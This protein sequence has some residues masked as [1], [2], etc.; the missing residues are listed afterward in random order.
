MT[1]GSDRHHKLN[2]EFFVKL[3]VDDGLILKANEI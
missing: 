1:L 2:Q 3:V